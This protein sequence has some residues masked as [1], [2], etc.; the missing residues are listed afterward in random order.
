MKKILIIA[1][2]LCFGCKEEIKINKSTHDKVVAYNVLAEYIKKE[3]LISPSTAVFPTKTEKEQ[4]TKYLENNTYLINSWV[5][6]E[7]ELG[8]L[9]KTNFSSKVLF[10]GNGEVSFADFFTF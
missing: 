2:I 10:K 8:V 5:E 3:R 1:L 6:S 7:N 9:I 4:H